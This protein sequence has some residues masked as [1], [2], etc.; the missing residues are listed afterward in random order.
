MKRFAKICPQRGQ[1]SR[2]PLFW[3]TALAGPEPG[4]Q[5][6]RHRNA[7][8]AVLG[9]GFPCRAGQATK[10]PGRGH[11][12]PDP[13]FKGGIAG[14]KRGIKSVGV[15]QHGR[16]LHHARTARHRRF[17]FPA[18]GEG[19]S[20]G[21]TRQAYYSRKPGTAH[22]GPFPQLPGQINPATP[23]HTSFSEISSSAQVTSRK[24]SFS[25][26]TLTSRTPAKT[27]SAAGTDRIA[28]I[29]RLPGFNCPRA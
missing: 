7:K 16:Y 26:M 29:F 23:S 22:P 1:R 4:G 27:A 2:R 11:A 14:Q 18:V 10:D 17:P 21:G 24:N 28:A 8:R 19:E 12:D 3:P 13:P 6:L 20:G 15:G 9:Q 25:G 5:A